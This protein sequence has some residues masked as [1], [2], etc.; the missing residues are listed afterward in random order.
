MATTTTEDGLKL[1]Y[2]L[3]GPE[4]ARVV[5]FSNSLGSDMSLWDGQVAGL[6]DRFRVLRYD[7]RGHG[8]SDA[9]AGDYVMESLARD[10]LGLLDHL[11]LDRVS[12]CGISMGGAIGQWL[13]SHAP[14]RFD[15]LILANTGA[16]FGTP[17]LWQQRL[18]AVLE[19]GMTAVVEGVLDRWFTPDYR[20]AH[21]AEAARVRAMLL[22]VPPQGYA[23]CC[24]ALRD[25]D[26]RRFLPRVAVPTLVIAGE[27]DAAS[28]PEKGQ[29]LARGIP[30]ARLA[31]LDAAHLSVLE[32]PRVFSARLREFL[33]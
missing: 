26:F 31:M 15:R 29:E 5:L 33:D 3:D 32:Q 8:G 7:T 9:P 28:P 22:A 11:G 27:H 4:G 1:H 16:L 10:V 24:A 14:E 19:G 12:F 20:A 30:G 2:R 21:P 13:G 17:Q 23:G 18:D 25:T 6:T